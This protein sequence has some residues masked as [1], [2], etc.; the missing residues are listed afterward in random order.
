MMRK[1]KLLLGL[2][3]LVWGAASLYCV[4][5]FRDRYAHGGPMP[6]S[7]AAHLLN[8]GRRL[9]HPVRRS[10]E[11][12]RVKPDDTVLEI[13]PGPGYFTIEAGRIVGPEGRVLSLDIQPEM[14]VIL[15]GRLRE[16]DIGN[17]HPLVGDAAR[18]PLADGCVDTA[19]LV[20]VLGEI[21]DRPAALT[22]LKRVLKPGGT[23][24]VVETLTDPDY[25]FVESTRDLCRATGFEVLAHSRQ[26]EGYAM[27]FT[28]PA[29]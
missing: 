25:V 22:E 27:S 12:C 15:R 3:L 13:G 17:A 2:F 26:L 14:A 9:L 24:S 29:G 19:V 5:W 1:L 7:H 23:L 4:L 18:L 16:T 10:L 6:A 21:A 28:V 8:P 11:E 20:A